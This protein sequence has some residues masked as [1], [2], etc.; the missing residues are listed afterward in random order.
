[1]SGRPYSATITVRCTV[2][3]CECEHSVPGLLYESKDKGQLIER[4]FQP[5]CAHCGHL[6]RG[7]ATV[8]IEKHGLVER[9]ETPRP[10]EG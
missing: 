1:M 6:S 5:E 7:H 2:A 4:S 8:N 3:G 9:R 10:S